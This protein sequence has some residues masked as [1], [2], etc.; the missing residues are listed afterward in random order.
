MNFNN[1]RRSLRFALA[2]LAAVA[3]GGTLTPGLARQ[4]HHQLSLT[5]IFGAPALSQD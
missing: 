3:L 2:L 1:I 4:H 5:D